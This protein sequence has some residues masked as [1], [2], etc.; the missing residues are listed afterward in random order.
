MARPRG[1]DDLQAE[2]DA[3]RVAS[4]DVVVS[5]LEISE[6]REL[7]LKHQEALCAARQIEFRSFPIP[8]RGTPASTR[9]FSRFIEELH[10]SLLA[11][12]SVAIHC[13][14]GIGRTGLVAGCLIN[15]LG[16]PPEQVFDLLSRSRGLPMPDT[17]AQVEWFQ[18]HARRA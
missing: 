7:G 15:R 16:V 3:W 10:A 13:R 8:D 4:V 5:L 1:D 17:Q 12:K 9:E 2:V 14:A 11:R 6:V 18:R